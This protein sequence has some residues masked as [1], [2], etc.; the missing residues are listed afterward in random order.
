M[1]SVHDQNGPINSTL[2]RFALANLHGNFN[3][4]NPDM[5]ECDI[6]LCARVT[7][8]LTVTNGTFDAGI[9]N[10]IEVVGVPGLYEAGLV[11]GA[12]HWYTFNI[13]GDHPNFP[14]NSS[15]SYHMIDIVGV[16]NFLYDIFTSQRTGGGDGSPYYWPLVN[17]SD[18]VKT[19]AAISQGMS[20][21]IAQA[22]SGEILEGEAF[23]SELYIRVQWLWI[24]LPLA[25]VLMSI[26][27][28]ACTLGYTQHKG[29]PAWKI[30]G[31]VPLLTVMMG[32]DSTELSGA[33]A[34]EIRKRSQ[35]MRGQLVTKHPDIQVFRRAD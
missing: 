33:S 3:M 25:E 35:Y 22:P 19:V 21:A 1:D 28:L 32:W 10:D 30:S 17:S 23:V 8:N 13:S 20:Y 15:F 7:R 34:R 31:I 11:G 18:H 29:V 2:A 24:I 6:R 4:S 14:G 16:K 26:A 5:L 9:S 12:R 27:L